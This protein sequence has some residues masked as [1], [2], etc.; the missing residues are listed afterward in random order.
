[1]RWNIW[2]NCAFCLFVVASFI[3]I[4]I[5]AY[6]INKDDYIYV[7]GQSIGLDVKTNVCVVE[8]MV[9]S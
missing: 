1:M 9:L 5:F 4:N 7:G 6:S 3:N 8:H 2:K